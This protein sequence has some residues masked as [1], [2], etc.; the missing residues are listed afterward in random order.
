MK[1]IFSK[2][3]LS[4]AV[5]SMG[6]ASVSCNDELDQYPIDY[7]SSGQYWKSEVE[8]TGNIYALSAMFR[9][10]YPANILFWAGELRAGTLTIDLINGS[11][12]LNVDYVQNLYDEAHA[13]FS[14]FGGYYGFIANL[15]ELIEHLGTVS[16]N[17]L[18]E[19]KKLALLGIAHGWR[20][21]SYFQMYRMYG[22]VPL[23]TTPDVV[24]GITNP[25]Q[26]YMKRGTATETL[27]LIKDDIKKSLES[28]DA[29]TWNFSSKKAYYWS[30]AATEMLAGEV[31]LWSG[32]VSTGDHTAT[33]ADVQTAKTYFENVVNN[34]GY[35]LVPNYFDVWTTPLNKESIYSICYSNPDDVD[36]D[37]HFQ[38]SA[39]QAQMLWSK[40][41]GA[42]TTAWSIQDASGLSIRKDG[43]A[44]RFGY[45]TNSI[46]AKQVAYTCWNNM[47]PSPN[48]YMY[49]NAMYF[50]FN[51]KD[52]RREMFFPQWNIKENEKNM[53]YVPNFDPTE[54]ELQGSFILKFRP[55]QGEVSWSTNYVW[56]IDVP[57]YRLPLAYMYLAEIANYNG[58]NANVEKYI[59]LVRARAYGE[60]WDEAT[61][62]Y[63]AGSFRENENAILREKDKEFIMEGQRWWDIR[64]LTAVK[65]G[66]PTDHFVFQPESC[67]GFGLDVVSNPWFVDNGGAPVATNTPVLTTAEAYKVLWP[68]DATLLGSDPEVKQNE[69][70]SSSK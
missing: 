11:G 16:E 30:K 3:A 61:Y 60:N 10:N 29:T 31:Y 38:F 45:F 17:I 5:A 28:F 21:F 48:R 56:N 1:T 2:I 51:E 53:T 37:G 40:S 49:K 22:G 46:D 26:L 27:A 34:Y 9:K 36:G 55:T 41:A 6:F 15:N 69:G 47:N 23:R 18:P 67:A 35:A 4:V 13:Q 14:T 66:S 24:N 62:G 19:N 59:N 68:I 64:R 42:G 33:P 70:Y 20:A 8:F 39:Y 44:S 52:L 57:I 12:A 43:G 50:Q 7:P 25:D 58:D 54:H 32:K 65:D 63:K